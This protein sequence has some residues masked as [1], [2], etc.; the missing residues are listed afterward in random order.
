MLFVSGIGP[1]QR[2]S[3]A[4][5]GVTFDED[6]KTVV[7]HDIRI[8]TRACIENI[9]TIIEEAGGTLANVVDVSAFLTDLEH[10]FAGF[11]EVYGE[12]FAAIGPTRTTVEVERLPTPINVEL[13]VIA[14]FT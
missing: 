7:A 8:Q 5:P 13:K 2:G 10:D 11:N 14:V 9:K 3:T 1:R 12:Y 4:I 6:G